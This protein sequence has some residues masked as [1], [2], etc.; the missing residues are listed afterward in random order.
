[1]ISRPEPTAT[2]AAPEARPGRP[3]ASRALLVGVLAAA[4]WGLGDYGL[5][6][7]SEIL[8]Y[9]LFAMSLDLVL[10]CAGLVSLGH[11]AFFG[12]GGYAFALLATAAG[13]P[14]AAAA[15]AAV[16]LAGVGG[17]LFGAVALRGRGVGFIM[18]T[19]A[20]AQLLHTI[21]FKSDWAG[22]SNGLVGVPR[23]AVATGE[24]AFYFVILATVAAAAWLA[25]RVVGSPVGRTLVGIRENA[26]RMAAMGYP[27]D[28]YRL[29]ALVLGALGAGAA[30][31]LYAGFTGY[32]GP[33]SLDWHASGEALIMV[34][35]GG[36]GTLRGPAAGAA[37]FILLREGISS[38]TPHWMLALGALLVGFV[39]VAPDGLAGLAR[40]AVARLRGWSKR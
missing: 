14:V 36:A 5:S 40:R 22:G 1:V 28:R 30:G 7:L 26:G 13:W 31:A 8:V 32:I 24:A 17:A 9:A 34:V 6:L 19:F 25:G 20:L 12:L 38:L 11:A 29:L 33:S 15:P 39:L 27:V 18:L 37:A 35:F 21:A 16:A 10:G 2:P 4:P 3:A 23:P